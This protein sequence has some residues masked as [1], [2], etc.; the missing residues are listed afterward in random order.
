MK[1]FLLKSFLMYILSFWWEI[2]SQRIMNVLFCVSNWVISEKDCELADHFLWKLPFWLLSKGFTSFE[3]SYSNEKPIDLVLPPGCL[4]TFIWSSML[5]APVKDIDIHGCLST[6]G[7]LTVG[8]WWSRPL[9]VSPSVS[10]KHWSPLNVNVFHA[11]A[12]K[13]I[14]TTHIHMELVGL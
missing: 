3:S 10:Q 12:W 6:P 13:Y 2:F 4:R 11:N 7:I 5:V 9:A 1:A 8:F 14:D